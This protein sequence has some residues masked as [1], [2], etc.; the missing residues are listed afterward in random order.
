MQRRPNVI[1]AGPALH[2]CYTN[3]LC[4]LGNVLTSRLNTALD[5][6]I[7]LKKVA[8]SLIT[9]HVPLISWAL[10]TLSTRLQ[11]VFFAD[12]VYPSVIII[13]WR[14]TVRK[15]VFLP[16]QKRDVKSMF[17]IKQA[18]VELLVSVGKTTL[19]PIDFMCSWTS[20]LLCKAKRQYLLILQVSRYC[21]LALRGRG[22]DTKVSMPTLKSSKR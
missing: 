13:N 3:V 1:D 16:Q 5:V 4:L 14:I 17:F 20:T 8:S 7:S 10:H 9:Q 12:S 22:I 18:L 15:N 19:D 2:K 21:R 6:H 11:G